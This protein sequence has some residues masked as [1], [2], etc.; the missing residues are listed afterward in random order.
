MH[1]PSAI[2]GLTEEG[3]NRPLGRH[4]F[5]PG[6]RACAHPRIA[7]TL[8]AIRTQPSLSKL[9]VSPRKASMTLVRVPPPIEQDVDLS[10]TYD[11]V[12]VGSGPASGMAAHA[13]TTHRLQA[14]MP[15]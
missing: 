7:R 5:Q 8:S 9:P 15:E 3:P 4:V 13:L 12:I 11:A 6:R 14:P 10:K 1:A 2:Q